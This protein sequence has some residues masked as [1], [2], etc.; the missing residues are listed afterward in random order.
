MLATFM[1]LLALKVYM[2]ITTPKKIHTPCTQFQIFFHLP[3][4]ISVFG[5]TLNSPTQFTVS[6][7]VL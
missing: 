4:F 1:V 2:E 5:N 7:P 6:R 3:T